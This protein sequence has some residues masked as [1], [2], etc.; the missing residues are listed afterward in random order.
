[1]LNLIAGLLLGVTLPTGPAPAALPLDHFP[2]RLHALVWRNWQI[3]PLERMAATVGG[4]PDELRAM[5]RSMGLTGPPAISDA[6]WRRSY[7]TVI[8]ANWHLL[9]FEQLLTLLDWS[10]E[11]LAYTLQEDDFLFT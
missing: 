10:P 11:R 7:I 8:R 9:P 4:T 3:T 2:D 6:Q 5:G 1:M